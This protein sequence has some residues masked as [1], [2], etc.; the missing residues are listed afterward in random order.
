M[1]QKVA[2][3]LKYIRLQT[4]FERDST[5]IRLGLLIGR[6]IKIQPERKMQDKYIWTC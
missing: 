1:K 6:K 2:C 3:E 4:D 5:R